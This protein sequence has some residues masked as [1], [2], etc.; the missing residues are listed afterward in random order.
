[1]PAQY[2][3]ESEPAVCFICSNPILRRSQRHQVVRAEPADL[4]PAFHLSA[5]GD[6]LNVEARDPLR[7][8]VLYTAAVRDAV[9]G[10]A[11]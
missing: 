7:L 10:Q 2:G 4:P 11:H 3:L 5:H 1:V 8:Y 6:C 9:H